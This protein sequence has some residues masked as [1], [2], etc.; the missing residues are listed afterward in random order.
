[1][2][3][4]IKLTESDLKKIVKK[5][6]LEQKFNTS[7]KVFDDKNETKFLD[8]VAI[9]GD[10]KVRG[11]DKENLE[12]PNSMIVGRKILGTLRISCKD[13]KQKFYFY[14]KTGGLPLSGYNKKAALGF[15]SP[16]SQEF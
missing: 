14:D 13:K 4:I 16:P 3:K 7:F 9:S 6:I 5:V 2:S 12:F 8:E 15:C 11:F 1:M 10:P